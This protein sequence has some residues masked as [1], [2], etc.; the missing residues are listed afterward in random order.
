M[1]ETARRQHHPAPQHR[2]SGG[3]VPIAGAMER[4]AV[5]ARARRVAGGWRKTEGGS[6]AASRHTPALR[7]RERDLDLAHGAARGTGAVGA[8]GHGGVTSRDVAYALA[9]AARHF[10]W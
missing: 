9:P 7:Q 6:D 8:A 1:R 5:V 2:N 10:A 3:L 4:A